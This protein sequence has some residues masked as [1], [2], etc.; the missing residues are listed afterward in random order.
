MQ[1][2]ERTEIIKQG[3]NPKGPYLRMKKEFKDPPPRKAEL[4]ARIKRTSK[5]YFQGL[6]NNGEQIT[7]PVEAIQYGSYTFR[8]NHNNYRRQDLSFYVKDAE[9]RFLKLH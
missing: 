3:T 2:R 4:F 9:G 7:F 6:D 1:E 5:Y 8:L